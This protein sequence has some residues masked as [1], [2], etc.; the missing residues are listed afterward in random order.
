MKA[1][2]R[3]HTHLLFFQSHQWKY[4]LDPYQ[5]CDYRCS[6]CFAL[7]PSAAPAT[8]PRGLWA[9]LE[10]DLAALKGKGIVFLSPRVDPYPPS[11]RERLVTRRLLEL[12][13]SRET[14]L[15][16][17][18]KS[19][20]IL[21]DADILSELQ[22]R[23]LV[24]VQFSLLT[25]DDGR[26]R[27][28]EP[29]ADPPSARLA[30]AEH[31]T[32]LGI[33]VHFHLAPYIP[34]F[35]EP[36]ELAATVEAVS[37]HGGR[38]LYTNPLGIRPGKREALAP[39]LN[40]LGGPAA[41]R[42]MDWYPE[43]NRVR[44]REQLPDFER[45]ADDMEALRDECL[46][47]GV[48][49]VCEF[50][51]GLSEVNPREF[52]EG[53]FRFAL[54]AVYQMTSFWSNKGIEKVGWDDF[55]RGFLSRFPAVD[56]RFRAALKSLWDRRELFA[57]TRLTPELQGGKVFYIRGDRLRIGP[58]GGGSVRLKRFA[59]VRLGL[60]EGISAFFRR[61]F[62]STA[63]GGSPETPLVSVVIPAFNREHYLPEAI[64][65]ILAQT[66]RHLE[67]IVVDDGSTDGTQAAAQRYPIRAIR[68]DQAG[69]GAARNRGVLS[70][71]GR[72]LAF[73]DSDD[74][75]EPDK[76][77][78]QL[79]T[80]A[81]DRKAEAVFGHVSEFFSLE[82]PDRLRQTRRCHDRPVP[83]YV[84]ITMLIKREA[85]FRVGLFETRWQVG[86][87]QSWFLRAQEAGLNMI[88]RPECVC[89]RRIHENNKGHARSPFTSQRAQILK[90]A[91]DRRRKGGGGGG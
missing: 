57:N 7:D 41:G 22:R 17:M 42:I 56:P 82:L 55:R 71:R 13:L 15:V 80:F 75:W 49:F 26:S 4:A 43:T 16:L 62:S 68:Q 28:L 51:P 25:R 20:L 81:A 85:F 74:L 88:M 18:T 11:E 76:L 84:P 38:C 3:Y 66:H 83:G 32:G 9:D 45:L 87:F 79:E 70:S 47:R 91:L 24:L 65:S 10:K 34:G 33:P 67:I 8:E 72:F 44:D 6:Y 14:P 77:A 61:T 50:I 60:A 59:R 36:G 39:H 37:A 64:K 23:G 2:R 48:Q 90:E 86:E 63:A 89:R 1:L 30:A 73:L 52:G 12:L 29:L 40:Q 19:A 53:V 5:S 54:P 46:A 69:S 31:L 27:L 58:A 21:R 35:Y 78:L